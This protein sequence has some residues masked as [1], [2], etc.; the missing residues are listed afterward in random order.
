MNIR[1]MKKTIVIALTLMC[2]SMAFAQK[3]ETIESIVS[4]SHEPEWYGQQAEVWQKIVD[5]NPKDE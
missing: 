2:N 4:N 3:A 1:G 5:A